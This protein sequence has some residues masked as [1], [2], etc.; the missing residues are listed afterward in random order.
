[1]VTLLKQFAPYYHEVKNVKD[2]RREKLSE[3]R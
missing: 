2:M 1:M 3:G